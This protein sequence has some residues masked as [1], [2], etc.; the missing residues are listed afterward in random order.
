[1]KGRLTFAGFAITDGNPF[2]DEGLPQS[3]GVQE[4]RLIPAKDRIHPNPSK[5]NSVSLRNPD[6]FTGQLWFGP[7]PSL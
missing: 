6:E 1:M 3:G 4:Q 2:G 5:I 7:E